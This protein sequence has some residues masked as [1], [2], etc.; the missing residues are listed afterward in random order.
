MR[1]RAGLLMV[2]HTTRSFAAHH[3]VSAVLVCRLITGVR[4]GLSGKSAE[5]KR[6]LEQLAA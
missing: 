4:P 2:G 3:G 5:L 1:I 6:K